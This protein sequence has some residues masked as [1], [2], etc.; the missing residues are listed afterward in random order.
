MGITVR[1]VVAA[2][3][4]KSITKINF[5]YLNCG[6]QGNNK[7]IIAAYLKTVTNVQK[8]SVT[9]NFMAVGHKM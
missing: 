2:P 7:F 4:N 5:Y 3:A 9:H 6:G 8:H 1:D